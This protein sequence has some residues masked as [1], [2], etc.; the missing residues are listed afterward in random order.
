[1]AA[2]ASQTAKRGGNAAPSLALAMAYWNLLF[3]VAFLFRSSVLLM[4]SIV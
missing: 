4:F 1:M 2:C 3:S